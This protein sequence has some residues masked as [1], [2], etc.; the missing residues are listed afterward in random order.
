MESMCLSNRL[1]QYG[2]GKNSYNFLKLCT[3][4]ITSYL[5]II[6][7]STIII[8]IISWTHN[9][10]GDKDTRHFCTEFT[11]GED[12]EAPENV[13]KQ[14]FAFEKSFDGTIANFHSSNEIKLEFGRYNKRSY[15]SGLP[16]SGKVS[17]VE[18]TKN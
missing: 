17:L 15:K 6:L 2:K 16:Y 3:N 8:W 4:M 1:F 13:A 10:R 7:W 18:F 14:E 12:F 9:Q 11:V 5:S